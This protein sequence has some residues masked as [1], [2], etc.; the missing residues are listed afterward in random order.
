[1]EGLTDWALVAN[2]MRSSSGSAQDM[3]AVMESASLESGSKDAGV[4]SSTGAGE[5][6]RAAAGVKATDA[7]PHPTAPPAV[8]ASAL[9]NAAAAS[10]DAKA[11][12]CESSTNLGSK[13]SKQLKLMESMGFG[14]QNDF[15]LAILESTNGDIGKAVNHILANSSTS[16]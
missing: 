15:V 13:Y 1:M 2:S 6:S 12:A 3:K 9:V 16:S 14:G 8:S 10:R 11:K 4:S 5:A 7:G